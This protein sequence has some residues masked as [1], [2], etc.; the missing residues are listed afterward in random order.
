MAKSGKRPVGSGRGGRSPGPTPPPVRRRAPG[1]GAKGGAGSAKRKRRPRRRG[2][3]RRLA[4]VLAW[5][6]AFL[7]L[8][9]AAGYTVWLDVRVRAEFE[10]KRWAL[11]ARV[12]ARPIEIWPGA[13]IDP[14]AMEEGLQRSGYHREDRPRRPGSYR[15]AGERFVIETR[16]FRFWDSMEPARRLEVGFDAGVVA[17]IDADGGP[18]PLAA[19]GPSSDRPNLS[20]SPRGSGDDPAGRSTS[21]APRGTGGSRGSPVLRSSRDFLPRHRARRVGEHSRGGRRAGRQHAHPAAREESLSLSRT[22]AASQSST[23]Q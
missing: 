12:Y 21:R 23:K 4:R 1:G 19:A 14:D 18:V 15:R 3:W 16:E 11:P 22:D 17:G 2:G 20:R 8:V 13:R 10:G 7:V 9:P 6:A 5:Q